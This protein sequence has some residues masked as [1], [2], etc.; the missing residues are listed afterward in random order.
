[1]KQLFFYSLHD[2]MTIRP[3]RCVPECPMNDTSP[4][5]I[6]PW[7]KRPLDDM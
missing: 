1:M 6:L 7:K 5:Q 2:V 4:G 3:G